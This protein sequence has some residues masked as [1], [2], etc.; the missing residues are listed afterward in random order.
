ML[1][2]LSEEEEIVDN[3]KGNRVLK[4]VFLDT[5]YVIYIYKQYY[6]NIGSVYF[7]SDLYDT[8]TK[9]KIQEVK[10]LWCMY[11]SSENIISDNTYIYYVPARQRIKLPAKSKLMCNIIS[12]E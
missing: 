10:S 5:R 7:R 6:K 9:S 1:K 8:V 4:I 12:R 11:F 2:A 3:D